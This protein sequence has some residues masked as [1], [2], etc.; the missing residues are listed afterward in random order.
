MHLDTLKS[1]GN[2]WQKAGHHRIYINDLPTL[3]GLS[4]TRYNTGNISRATLDGERL[5][6]S[7]AM[8]LMTDLDFGKLWWDVPTSQWQS[9][10]LSEQAVR[11]LIDAIEAKCSAEVSLCQ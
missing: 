9:K 1:L 2:E 5:S 8:K 4:V 6:N 7:N 3:Y 11:R 10:G